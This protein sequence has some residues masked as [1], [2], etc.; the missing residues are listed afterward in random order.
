MLTPHCENA[1]R[2]LFYRQLLRAIRPDRSKSIRAAYQPRP[3]RAAIGRFRQCVIPIFPY[4]RHQYRK[5]LD[6]VVYIHKVGWAQ[7]II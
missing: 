3:R 1:K 4:F 7:K 6:L 5:I 2:T